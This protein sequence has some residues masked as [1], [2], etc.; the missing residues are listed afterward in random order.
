MITRY[1]Y[2]A[3]GLVITLLSVYLVATS[4]WFPYLV[5]IVVTIAL[6]KANIWLYKKKR[7]M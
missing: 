5:S 6:I 1:L 3:F 4:T 2:A 7:R